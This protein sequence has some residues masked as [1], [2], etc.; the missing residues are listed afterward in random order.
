V[1]WSLKAYK[2]YLS[3]LNPASPINIEK[4]FSSID[5]IIIK[6]V[7]SG[8]PL[9]WNGV[10]MFVPNTYSFKGSDTTLKNNNCFEL[11]GFDILIDENLKPWLLEVNLSPSLSTDSLLDF[12][13][14]C[15]VLSDLFSMVGLKSLDQQYIEVNNVNPTHSSSN[16]KPQSLLKKNFLSKQIQNSLNHQADT[17]IP[18][19]FTPTLKQDIQDYEM[20]EA[21]VLEHARR[22]QFRRLFPSSTNHSYYS[23]LLEERRRN[24]DLLHQYHNLNKFKGQPVP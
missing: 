20:I 3:T 5:D 8:E 7:I 19:P 4:L 1:K 23:N 16:K 14:K 11:L 9:L 22:G 10:E 21:S 24:D 13:I 17:A 18:F 15:A 2:R 12:K 6:T